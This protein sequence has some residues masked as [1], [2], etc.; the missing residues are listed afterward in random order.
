MK[1]DFTK[2]KPVSD[3]VFSAYRAMYAYPDR[4]LNA[5]AGETV[6]ET[7]DWKKEKIT[8]DDAYDHERMTA[9]LYLPKHIQAPYETVVFFP[10]ARVQALT[11]SNVLGDTKFFDY[12]VQSGRAVMYP[13]YEGTY[14][15]KKLELWPI[16]LQLM[17]EQASDL[18]RSVEYLR[19]RSD[20]NSN[21]LAFVGVSMGSAEGVVFT[22][23]LQDK[24]RTVV[25]LDGGYFPWTMP[26]G[27][28]Q[29]EFAP[30]LKLPVLM[31]N[32]RYDFSFPLHTAQEPLFSMLGTPAGEKEHLVLETP[33]DV[34]VR[35]PQLVKNVLAWL[36]K[37]LG[38][39]E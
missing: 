39:V 38:A 31:V 9:Y 27:T 21:K 2:V 6:E 30:R 25:L 32:G 24:F 3:Q 5:K 11:N 13:I 26:A 23:L 29:A 28:D 12:I 34:T 8:F 14:E 7:A 4:P 22:T 20:I 15:R 35:R 19:T 36:D 10:S 17:T 1:R 33:H 37:Y 18:R 16:T